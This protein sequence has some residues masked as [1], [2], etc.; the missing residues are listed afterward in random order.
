MTFHHRGTEDTE[1]YYV[2]RAYGAINNKS[3]SLCPLCLC[4][5]MLL[6]LLLMLLLNSHFWQHIHG[7]DSE[8]TGRCRPFFFSQ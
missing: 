2:N 7:C 6:M 1:F 4:G 3:F 8:L 5:E